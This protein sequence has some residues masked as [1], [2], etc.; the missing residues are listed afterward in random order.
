MKAARINRPHNALKKSPFGGFR[1]LLFFFLSACVF[2]PIYDPED[3]PGS[4]LFRATH[5]CEIRLFDSDTIQIARDFYEVGKA[6]FIVYMKATGEYIVH[7]SFPP[8]GGTKG[9]Y[10]E[11]PLTYPGGNIEYY[12]EFY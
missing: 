4:I 11:K 10:F 5:D 1:G 6:P 8:S 7:A 2:Y 3:L 12:I 9:G